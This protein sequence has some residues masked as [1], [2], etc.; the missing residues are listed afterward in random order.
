MIDIPAVENLQK[1]LHFSYVVRIKLPKSHI[2]ANGESDIT[3][4]PYKIY[5]KAP[6]KF[7]TASPVVQSREVRTTVSAI[8]PTVQSKVASVLE[9]PTPLVPQKTLADTLTAWELSIE[10]D[11]YSVEIQDSGTVVFQIASDLI[12]ELH[13]E[14][15]GTISIDTDDIFAPHIQNEK[16]TT[17]L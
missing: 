4:P 14:A 17:I 12:G 9:T 8:V 3:L 11:S 16:I 1:D 6:K 2:F 10:E 13:E 7:E 5:V 15:F